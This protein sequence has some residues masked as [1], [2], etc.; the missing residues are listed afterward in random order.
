[1]FSLHQLLLIQ[2][3]LLVLAEIIQQQSSRVIIRV[4]KNHTNLSQISQKGMV[5]SSHCRQTSHCIQRQIPSHILYISACLYQDNVLSRQ[6]PKILASVTCSMKITIFT[7]DDFEKMHFSQILYI[8][9]QKCLLITVSWGIKQYF[10][11]YSV[12]SDLLDLLSVGMA[13]DHGSRRLLKSHFNFFSISDAITEKYNYGGKLALT[14][15]SLKTSGCY[16][17][18]ALKKTLNC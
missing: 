2:I 5:T 7:V 17:A 13:G 3:F 15:K 1:M 8:L 10:F 9:S 16:T 11:A 6:K 12:T 14:Y 18:I 4:L